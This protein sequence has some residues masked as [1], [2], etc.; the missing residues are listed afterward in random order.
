VLTAYFE[1]FNADQLADITEHHAVR[2]QM[3]DGRR[4][5]KLKNIA[6][7]D[8]IIARI[9]NMKHWHFPTVVGI[10]NAPT[11]RADGSLLTADGYDKATQLWHKSS[12]EVVLPPIPERP[13]KADAITALAKLN[14]LL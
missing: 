5:N 13:T 12:G 1:P 8:L 9:L 2:F 7:P 11:M 14:G 10:I 3:F 6:A 4:K